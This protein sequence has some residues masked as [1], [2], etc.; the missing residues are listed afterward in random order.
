MS[1]EAIRVGDPAQA[2]GGDSGDAKRNSVAGAQFGFAIAQEFDEGAV[3]VAEAKEAEIVGLNGKPLVRKWNSAPKGTLNNVALTA[4]LKAC[5][6][7]K[8]Y[9]TRA[10]ACLI[11]T[12]PTL[13]A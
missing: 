1:I 4:R 9:V 12:D 11:R 2:A 10:K 7:T 3:D 13:G 8:L 5:P 6:D